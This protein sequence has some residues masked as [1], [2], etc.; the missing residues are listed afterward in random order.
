[1]PPAFG[2]LPHRRL[3][4]EERDRLIHPDRSAGNP[5]EFSVGHRAMNTCFLIARTAI[6]ALVIVVLAGAPSLAEDESI[7][8]P[9]T[10]ATVPGA[11]P[12]GCT[13]PKVVCA[14]RCCAEDQ[15]CCNGVC[16]AKLGTCELTCKPSQP[17]Q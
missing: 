2:Q 16:T 8:H 14:G 17:V 5:T 9:P 4:L 7:T 15:C 3:R 6:L 11:N 12:P 10:T 13:L 1:M